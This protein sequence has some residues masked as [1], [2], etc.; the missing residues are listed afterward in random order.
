MSAETKRLSIVWH[1]IER[2]AFSPAP[3]DRGRW[4]TVY[5]RTLPKLWGR[6]VPDVP[7]R[8]HSGFD[9]DFLN[10]A[11]NYTIEA[12]DRYSITIV[13]AATL[14]PACWHL[15]VDP[16]YC[17]KGAFCDTTGHYPRQDENRHLARDVERV[18]DGMI[19]HPRNHAHGDAVG[20]VSQLGAD[21]ALPAAKIRLGGGVENGYVFLTHLRYQF[22]LLSE[23]ARQADRTRLIRLF[24]EAIRGRHPMVSAAELFD[25]RT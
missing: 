1:T 15:H 21:P 20:I 7:I 5:E 17:S 4:L 8:Q 3:A 14:P 12:P 24:T 18:L 19:F 2:L 6:Q 23:D 13:N 11:C 25:L 9:A 22:C 10:V 16:I